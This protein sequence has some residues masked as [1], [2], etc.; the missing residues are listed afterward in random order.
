MDEMERSKKILMDSGYF[1]TNPGSPRGC[2]PVEH[3]AR[4]KDGRSY[5][6]RARGSSASIEF[7]PEWGVWPDEGFPDESCAAQSGSNG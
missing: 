3:V 1:E 5:Y 7:Y 2:C 6:F 4:L